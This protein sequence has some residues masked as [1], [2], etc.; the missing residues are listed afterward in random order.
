MSSYVGVFSSEGAARDAVARLNEAG[1]G[2]V[3][4]LFSGDVAG[5][6][7]P[8]PAAAEPKAEAEGEGTNGAEAPAPAP[9]PAASRSSAKKSAKK[10]ARAMVREAVEKGVIPSGNTRACVEALE[11][12]ESVVGVSTYFGRGEFAVS[13]LAEKGTI[14]PAAPDD[15]PSPLSDF[16]GLDVLREYKSS[17]KLTRSSWTFSSMLGLGLLSSNPTPLSS[18]IGFKPLTKKQSGWNSSLGLPILTDNPAPFSSL[19]GWKPLTKGGGK[20]DWEFSFGFP[21][22]SSN[23][24]PISSLFGLKVLSDE[25]EEKRD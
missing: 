3:E 2:D 4:A 19:I 9:K 14:L 23:P 17:T 15:D 13:I 8:A 6:R 11:N 22:L 1:F 7:A 20:D 25:G 18:A 5:G 12:G 24:T 10:D 16:L 21:L